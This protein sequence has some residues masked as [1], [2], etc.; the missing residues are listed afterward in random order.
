MSPSTNLTPKQGDRIKLTGGRY[1]GQV[2]KYGG[3]LC[4]GCLHRIDLDNSIVTLAPL[5]WLELIGESDSDNPPSDASHN[6]H[7]SMTREG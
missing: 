4:C 5:E 3:E 1:A 6:H 2:G 7:V